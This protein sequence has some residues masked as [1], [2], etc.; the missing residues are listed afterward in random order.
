M[1]TSIRRFVSPKNVSKITLRS[2][3]SWHVGS[4][5]IGCSTASTENGSPQNMHRMMRMSGCIAA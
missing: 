1:I 4:A 3:V 2:P 5:R